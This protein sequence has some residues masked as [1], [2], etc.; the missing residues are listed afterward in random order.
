MTGGRSPQTPCVAPLRKGW[1]GGPFAYSRGQNRASTPLAIAISACQGQEHAILPLAP[2]LYGKRS[3]PIL[4]RCQITICHALLLHVLVAVERIEHRE[5]S[6]LL[7]R[8]LF[9]GLY[10]TSR[11]LARTALHESHKGL[12]CLNMFCVITGNAYL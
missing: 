6:V 3:R 9:K 12:L 2:L 7:H 5:N 10:K 4:F 11:P 8:R 1:L